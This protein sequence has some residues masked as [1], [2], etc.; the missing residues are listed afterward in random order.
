M[1][2]H[3]NLQGSGRA[4]KRARDPR[5]VRWTRPSKSAMNS[6]SR[7]LHPCQPNRYV[8]RAGNQFTTCGARTRDLCFIAPSLQP[9]S[10]GSIHTTHVVPVG[11]TMC[12]W[13]ARRRRAARRNN[14]FAPAHFAHPTVHTSSSYYASGPTIAHHDAP[15]APGTAE[16][17]L[18]IAPAW[19]VTRGLGET[20][21]SKLNTLGIESRPSRMLGGGCTI[22]P[23]AH[24]PAPIPCIAACHRWCTSGSPPI[25]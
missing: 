17:S 21:N 20:S 15:R 11:A 22:S 6:R 1:M 12:D 9:L 7:I 23:C 24:L 25:G 8:I 3:C 5:Q 16:S 19:P 2:S 10:W 13:L 4:I 14:R 18:V